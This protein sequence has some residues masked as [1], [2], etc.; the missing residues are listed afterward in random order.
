V[1]RF[2]ER[3]D[4]VGPASHRL[5]DFHLNGR[6][7]PLG[8]GQL[9]SAAELDHADPLAPADELG[10]L[11]SED[12]R[13]GD[14]PD[15]LLHH[16]HRL[17]GIRLA[18]DDGVGFVFLRGLAVVHGIDEFAFFIDDV[19]HLGVAGAAV[20]MN[21]EDRQ[22]NP[23]PHRRPAEQ[24]LVIQLHDVRHG[25]IGGAD[26]DIFIDGDLPLGI[27]EK[28]EQPDQNGDDEDKQRPEDP[29]QPEADEGEN[30]RTDKHFAEAVTSETGHP[31]KL[32]VGVGDVKQRRCEKEV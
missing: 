20:D 24:R 18:E 1:N 4:H 2:A 22:E 28:G 32:C 30:D 26:E 10:H 29:P 27:A 5:A 15:D 12:D 16:R 21:V 11:R 3:G 8:D 7:E 23:H 13:A 25:P 31:G 6:L 17:I 9:G 14:Q 19:D